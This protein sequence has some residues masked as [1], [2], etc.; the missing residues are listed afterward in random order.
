KIAWLRQLLEGD[1][2]AGDADMLEAL[3]EGVFDDRVYA[4]TPRGDIVDLPAGATPLDFAYHVHTEIGHRCKGARVN[5]RIVTLTYQLANGDRVEIITAK[6]AQPSRDWLSSREGFLVS[7]RNRTKV[8]SW[9]RQQD[10]DLNRKQGREH[11]E[12]ELQRLNIRD[13]AVAK[14]ADRMGFESVDDL[15]VALGVGDITTAA[16]F[17]AVQQL[18]APPI[19]SAPVK[20]RRRHKPSGA[21]AVLIEGAESVLT[22]FARCCNPV[23]PEPICGYITQGRGISVHRQNCGSLLRLQAQ[24]P[25]RVLS[26]SWYE[27]ERAR[28]PVTIRIEAA[29][30]NG[31]L[32]DLSGVMSDEEIRIL[33][34]DARV[35]PKTLRAVVTLRAEVDGLGTLARVM[36][37]LQQVRGVERVSRAT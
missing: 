28:Y 31:L 12:R 17:N 4:I 26:A 23:P 7:A 21:G 36:S 25:D 32:K 16:V 34:N 13:L 14:L 8:R 3:S 18:T 33:G 20:K 2:D 10:R 6:E 5:G 35:S 1:D 24:H 11:L 27:D 29:D 19:E 22:H 9:F 37:R 30:R 15:C